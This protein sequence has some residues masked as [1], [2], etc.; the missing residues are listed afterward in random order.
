MALLSGRRFRRRKKECIFADGYYIDHA[1]DVIPATDRTDETFHIYGNDSPETDVQTNYGTLTLGV[2]DKYTNNSLQ[3]LLHGLDP[4]S[5]AVKQY[6]VQDLT[7]V[8]IW[9]NVKNSDNSSYIKSWLLS[10]W[11]PA[12]PLALPRLPSDTTASDSVVSSTP[13]RN[14]MR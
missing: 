8:D 13:R 14:A 6:R 10:G 1:N 4:D 5:N 11:T 12:E 9:A 2:L 7:S 3:D